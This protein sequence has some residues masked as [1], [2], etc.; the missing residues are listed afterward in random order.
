MKVVEALDECVRSA[1]EGDKG[2]DVVGDEA[3]TGSV[4]CALKRTV[5]RVRGLAPVVTYNWYS[6]ILSSNVSCGLLVSEQKVSSGLHVIGSWNPHV[7]FR[8][9]G[10]KNPVKPVSVPLMKEVWSALKRL[11]QSFERER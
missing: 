3:V 11:F 7:P 9:L 4:N 1:E 10:W 8:N 6:Q 5:Q 2:G